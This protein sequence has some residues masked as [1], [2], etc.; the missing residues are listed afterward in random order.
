MTIRART[1]RPADWA[2]RPVRWA[3]ALLAL[4]LLLGACGSPNPQLVGLTPIPT[5]APAE[6]VTL[7]PALQ[8]LSGSSGP[9]AAAGAALFETHCTPCHGAQAEGVIGP[10]LRN[11]PYIQSASDQSIHATIEAGRLGKGMPAWYTQDGGPLTQAEIASI[12]D[13]LKTLQGVS[14]V[15]ASTPV[16]AEPTPTPLPAGAPTPQPAQPSEP[17]GPGPAASMTGDVGRGMVAFGQNC[18]VCH[19]PEGVLGIPNPGSDDG[20]V[21]D[22]NPIDPTIANPNPSIFA[23][24]VDLFIEHGSVPAGPSPRIIMPSFGDGKMLADQEIADLI[25][26]VMSLNGVQETK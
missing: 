25:A 2:Y 13:Y 17:G 24:N 5:L 11:S 4:V 20:S 10:A 22:L 1:K 26:Y 6:Q 15:P 8:T 3:P 16:P 21:P 18:A 19:G 9:S 14:P 12:V 7:V 23:V